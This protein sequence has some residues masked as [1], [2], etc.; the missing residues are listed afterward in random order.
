MYRSEGFLYICDLRLVKPNSASGKVILVVSQALGVIPG[1]VVADVVRKHMRPLPNHRED[2]YVHCPGRLM[3]V[4]C[5]L[6][7]K[8]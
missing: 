1:T 7:A 4:P 3:R 5:Y 2:I 8:V 6:F